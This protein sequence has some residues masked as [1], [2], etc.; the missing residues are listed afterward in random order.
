MS[1]CVNALPLTNLIAILGPLLPLDG[2]RCSF[3]QAPLGMKSRRAITPFDGRKTV[4]VIDY[5]NWHG[6]RRSRRVIPT[7]L[8]FMATEH[9]T[10]PQWILLAV[11]MEKSANR[12]F[13]LKNVH[14]PEALRLE[15]Y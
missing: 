7:G 2:W 13:A 11:D 15:V 12:A 4:V 10:T 6:E 14:N 8:R 3:G 1:N 5:T 9:N